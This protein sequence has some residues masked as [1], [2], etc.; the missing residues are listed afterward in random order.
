MAKRSRSSTKQAPASR[1]QRSAKPRGTEPERSTGRTSTLLPLPRRV[2]RRDRLRS[3]RRNCGC[4]M[5]GPRPGSDSKQSSRRGIQLPSRS[6]RRM[7]APLSRTPRFASACTSPIPTRTA[8]RKS[9]CRRAFTAWMYSKQVLRHL[10]A[11]LTFAMTSPSKWKSLSS[12]LK[13][14][15]RTGCSIQRST[16]E[17]FH[18]EPSVSCNVV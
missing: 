15:T 4:L 13:I 16:R 1:R 14:P 11:F 18:V 6:F 5:A 17:A 3:R 9:R 7:R 2:R 10:H 12:R 8:L